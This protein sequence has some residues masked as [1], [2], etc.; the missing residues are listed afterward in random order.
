[1]KKRSQQDQ[2]EDPADY[3]PSFYEVLAQLPVGY[4]NLSLDGQ[5]RLVRQVV[6]SIKL[7]LV[8]KHMFLLHIEW[9]N[10]IAACPDVALIW[11]G[12]TPN[13][14]DPWTAR[15]DDAMRSLYPT[16][17]QLEL[18]KALPDRAWDRIYKRAQDLGLRRAVKHNGP[19]PLLQYHRTMSYGDL[20]VV[21]SL[22]QEPHEQE[23]MR[24]VANELARKTMR[25]GLSAHWWLPLHQVSLATA[26]LAAASN[27]DDEKLYVSAPAYGSLRRGGSSR[28]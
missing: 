9:Q 2:L 5:R 25:G 23:L 21:A 3:L 27:A 15:E 20:E 17:S 24:T 10:G 19:H 7:N 14:A 28:R 18:M 16:A 26:L 11:R 22:V 12:I 6:R 13:T 8:S 1:M 4:K